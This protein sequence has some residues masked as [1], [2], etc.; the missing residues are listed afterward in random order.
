MTN[1]T[2]ETSLEHRNQ[3]DKPQAD[4]NKGDGTPHEFSFRELFVLI[5]LVFSFWPLIL[6]AIF[7]CGPEL[8]I[9]LTK[10]ESNALADIFSPLGV[11]FAG[12]G[13]A[14]TF[15]LLWNDRRNSEKQQKLLIEQNKLLKYEK[16]REAIQESITAS[17]SQEFTETII[18]HLIKTCDNLLNNPWDITLDTIKQQSDY[19]KELGEWKK[20]TAKYSH[21][22]ISLLYCHHMIYDDIYEDGLP[23]ME[24]L[25]MLF[26]L[27]V[28]RRTQC[29]IVAVLYHHLSAE[30]DLKAFFDQHP[31][32]Q[33]WKDSF[34]KRIRKIIHKKC[35]SRPGS[36]SKE[37]DYNREKEDKLYT[38]VLELLSS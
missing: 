7:A 33:A 35:M 34:E 2:K 19:E 1:K 5:M 17:D 3:D 23:F 20:L 9:N 29:A 13:V 18:D 10:E 16:I 31:S 37:R 28:D 6:K 32:R 38:V 11:L 21:I 30:G 27:H 24:G 14:A 15:I 25:Q 8:E 26:A 4:S 22:A 12:C 36:G